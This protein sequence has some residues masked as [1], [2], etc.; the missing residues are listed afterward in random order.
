MLQILERIQQIKLDDI[1]FNVF[2]MDDVQQFIIE[3]NTK[4][5][6]FDSGEDSKGKSLASIGG[7]YLQSTIN[8]KRR[9]GLPTDRVTL[10]HTGDFYDT[11]VV[12]PLRNGDF[13]IDSN[14]IK[15]DTVNLFDRYGADVEGLQ[16]ES[17][18]MLT[19]FIAP[20][21]VEEFEKFVQSY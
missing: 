21:I 12:I 7:A 3:L 10:F 6:L 5:Q 2:S 1:L 9:L 14:P 15:E 19:A 17:V 11:F 16:K 4:H 8:I 18:E 13:I 20:L